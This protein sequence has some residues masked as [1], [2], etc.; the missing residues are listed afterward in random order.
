MKHLLDELLITNQY[1][2]R[3]I[4]DLTLRHSIFSLKHVIHPFQSALKTRHK[5]SHYLENKNKKDKSN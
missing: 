2:P 5:P 1:L 4:H 3:E